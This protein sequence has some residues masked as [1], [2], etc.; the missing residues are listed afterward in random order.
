MDNEVVGCIYP[1]GIF[2]SHE[3]EG[4]PAIC[5]NMDGPYTH[6]AKWNNSETERQI[7]YDTTYM[8]NLKS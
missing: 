8:W 1:T 2:F 4:N 6:Y 3:K 7:L 5:D